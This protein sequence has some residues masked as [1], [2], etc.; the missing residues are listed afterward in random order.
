MRCGIY[1]IIGWIW[2]CPA[3]L[4]AQAPVILSGSVRNGKGEPLPQST[5]RLKDSSGRRILAFSLARSDGSFVLRQVLTLDSIYQLE[6][7]HIQYQLQSRVLS[8]SPDTRVLAG[9]DFILSARV[10][11]LDEVVIRAKPPA[12]SIR[13]DTAEF[14]ASAYRTAESRKVEDL[15]RSMPGFD[16]S[17]DGRIHFNGKEVDRILVEGDDLTEKNYRLL[18]RN[19]HAGL[20]DK[21][22]VMSRYDENRLMANV[23]NPEKVGINLTIDPKYLHRWS[24][25][26]ETGLGTSGERMADLNLVRLAPRFKLIQFLQHNTIGLAANVDMNHYFR[27]GDP[28]AASSAQE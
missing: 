5:I 6:I 3:F 14:R 25:T 13:G 23:T 19:L 4:C 12:F 24:G 26:L 1:L 8:L 10:N 9:L 16:I 2:A 27:D 21:V 18:S 7:G 17:G 22:Q 20:V 28:V 11:S 15:L